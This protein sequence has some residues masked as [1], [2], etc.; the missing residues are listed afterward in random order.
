[1]SEELAKVVLEDPARPIEPLL[2]HARWA[3]RGVS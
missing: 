1:V 3:M 2:D